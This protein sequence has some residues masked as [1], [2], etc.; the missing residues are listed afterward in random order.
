[1]DV[2]FEALDVGNAHILVGG[3][4]GQ[5]LHDAHRAGMAARTVVQPRFLVGLRHHHQ[6]VEFI[7]C[8][9][10]LEQVRGFVEF[11]HFRR[12]QV[13]A[14][15]G[16]VLQVALEEHIAE[17]GPFAV[18]TQEVIDYGFQFR[19]F[20]AHGPGDGAAGTQFHVA[21]QADLV[22]DLVPELCLV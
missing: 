1:M 14:D 20:P 22:K 6:P 16:V 4:A 5:H 3:G 19:R 21:V 11:L 8:G 13:I 2:F 17:Q 18:A 7:L 12:G 10:L 9:V 15:V